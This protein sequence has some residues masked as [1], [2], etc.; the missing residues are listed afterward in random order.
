MKIAYFDCLSGISGDMILGALLDAGLDQ[1]DEK[2]LNRHLKLLKL[3]GWSLHG[4]KVT[5]QGLQATQAVVTCKDTEDE[6]HLTE[7]L[8]IIENSGLDKKI[9]QQSKKIF[10]NLGEAEA[11]IHNTT[12]DHIHFHEVGAIDAI[13]DIVGCVVGLDLLGIKKV[14]CSELPVGTGWIHFSHGIWPSPAP[15]TLELLKNKNAPV[16]IKDITTE[17]VTPT[18]AAIITTIAEFSKPRMKLCATGYGAGTKDLA[19]PNV[20]RVM[21]GETKK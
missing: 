19:H 12:L 3:D 17:L 11:K 2:K 10:T 5:K 21:I 6:R 4:E 13:I 18:G 8:E 15:A 14:Y 20:L 1:L 16:V 9:K 7:I